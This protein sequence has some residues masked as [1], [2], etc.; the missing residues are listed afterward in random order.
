M[1]ASTPARPVEPMRVSARPLRYGAVAVVLHWA[2]AALILLDFAYALSFS[3]FDRGDALYLPSAYRLHMSTGLA[4]LALSVLR[5]AWRLMHKV[6]ALPADMHVV[7]RRLAR[8][9]HLL[10]YG[11]M[12]VAPLTGWF[13]L[14]VR[15]QATSMFG[16][17]TWP[18][19]S[20]LAAMP[21]Q[22]R[23]TYH[24]ALLPLHIWISYAGIA[25]VGLHVSAAL[26]HHFYR[27]DDVLRR[28]LPLRER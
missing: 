13:V 2:I 7:L 10:L 15:K 3:R 12:L 27:R 5:V 4:V 20:L 9:S 14:S 11:F 17:F 19:F 18:D 24:D 25:L 6:P 1:S 21:H 22:Q 23:V 8:L 16:L 26:Y 28:M